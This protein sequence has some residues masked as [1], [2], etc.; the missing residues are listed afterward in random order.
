MRAAYA[1]LA[2]TVALTACAGGAPVTAAPTQ[3]P[4]VAAPTAAVA[5]GEL[6]PQRRAA[7]IADC[8]VADSHV[9]ARPDGLPD[10]TL[11]CLGGDSRV[12]LAGLRGRPMVINLWAQWCGPCRQEAPALRAIGE[13]LGDR[14]LLLGVDYADP[15]PELAIEFAHQAGWRHPQL[16]DADK[17]LAG[18]LRLIGPPV[19][20]FVAADGRIV[21]RHVGPFASPDDA[22]AQID[23]HLGVRP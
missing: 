10:I 1:A 17:T 22:L 3:A 21:A 13:Q 2:A 19:T 6:L 15:R 20:L 4:S 7:G 16:V 9:S 8:P 23:R 18:P 5:A 14:V 11:D 12:R